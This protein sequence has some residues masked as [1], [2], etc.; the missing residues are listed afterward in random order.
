MTCRLWELDQGTTLLV[1]EGHTGPIANCALSADGRRA[2]TTSADLTRRVWELDSGTQ[3]L[4]LKGGNSVLRRRAEASPLL[5]LLRK[6]HRF[7]AGDEISNLTGGG[8][9]A[10]KLIKIG[11]MLGMTGMTPDSFYSASMLDRLSQQA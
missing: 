1:L 3:M 11:L 8:V 4:A 7:H 5:A 10:A 6:P 2:L 9:S